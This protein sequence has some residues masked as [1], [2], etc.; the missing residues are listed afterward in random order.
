M[1]APEKPEVEP[2]R[3]RY[4]D[5]IR[6]QPCS[7][8]NVNDFCA[9]DAEKIIGEC[10]GYYAQEQGNNERKYERCYDVFEQEPVSG[11]FWFRYF[12]EQRGAEP[13]RHG[14]ADGAAHL[15]ESGQ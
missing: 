12:Q 3:E 10:E 11:Y 1:A 4:Q 8:R 14:A 7:D 2:D 5:G 13:R 6:H 15:E 9:G